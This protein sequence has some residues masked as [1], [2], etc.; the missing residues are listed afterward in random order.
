MKLNHTKG[1]T[2]L[3]LLLAILIAGGIAAIGYSKIEKEKQ[4]TRNK[5]REGDVRVIQQGLESFYAKNGS[6]PKK[7]DLSNQ[8]WRTANFA[9]VEQ[10]SLA[11]PNG[12]QI[13]EAGGYSYEPTADGSTD[14]LAPETKCA[15][16]VLSAELEKKPKLELKSYY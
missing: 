7:S 16:Y 9:T 8:E 4:T 11:D 1:F 2:V 12:P 13:N 3:E 6:Y 5:E 14:C 15:K 10:E